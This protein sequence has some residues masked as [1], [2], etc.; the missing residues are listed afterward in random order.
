MVIIVLRV[1]EYGDN[2]ANEQLNRLQPLISQSDAIYKYRWI[3][4]IL[5][6]FNVIYIYIY[7]IYYRFFIS[8]L[9][10]YEI[11]GINQNNKLKNE[12]RD[13]T[14]SIILLCILHCGINCFRWATFSM[15]TGNVIPKLNSMQGK[16][17]NCIFETSEWTHCIPMTR[18]LLN[19]NRLVHE[20][21]TDQGLD[22]HVTASEWRSIGV[23]TYPLHGMP[24]TNPETKWYSWT[25]YTSQHSVI[26]K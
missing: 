4:W 22:T 5:S 18:S 9:W 10:L 11:F 12:F 26:S 16:S 25:Q 24:I 21:Y 6:Q 23:F 8:V 13:S 14:K 2:S 1:L 20:W 7:N 19:V 15:E 3:R 17:S